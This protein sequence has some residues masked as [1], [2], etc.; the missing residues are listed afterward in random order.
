MHNYAYS[1]FC[2]RRKC[3]SAICKLK[4]VYAVSVFKADSQHFKTYETLK[5]RRLDN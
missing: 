1:A 5:Q 4:P 3:I 2:H